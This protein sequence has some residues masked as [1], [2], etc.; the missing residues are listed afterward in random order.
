MRDP[1]VW[2]AINVPDSFGTLRPQP[3]LMNWSRCDHL[4]LKRFFTLKNPNK[5]YQ[6]GRSAQLSEQHT[7]HRSPELFT[8]LEKPET[9]TSAAEDTVTFSEQHYKPINTLQDF[10]DLILKASYRCAKAEMLPQLSLPLWHK[11]FIPAACSQLPAAWKTPGWFP[12]SVITDSRLQQ[13]TQFIQSLHKSWTRN[14]TRDR[15]RVKAPL[16]YYWNYSKTNANPIE[17]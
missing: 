15:N 9:S 4:G 13:H 7:C 17:R 6:H 2:R 3:R 16:C 11:A 8:M 12:N 14:Y 5:P 1:L 10:R